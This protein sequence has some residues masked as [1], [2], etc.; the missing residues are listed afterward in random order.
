MA[1]L[2][3]EH[4]YGVQIRES[5][6]DGSDF[7]NPDADYRIAFLGEDGKWH[8]KDSAGTV[9]DPFSGS[10][11]VATDAIWDAAGD[12]AQ[13]TGANT[14]A[15]LTLGAAGTVV[16]STGST[17]AY[18][19]PPGYEF[20]YAQVTSNTNVTGTTSGA[21]NTIITGNAVTYDG[22]TIVLAEFSSA[23][24]RPDS[25]AGGRDL[26][27][28]LFEGSTAIASVVYVTT[29]AAATAFFAVRGAYRFTPSA[30]A[31]TYLIKAFVSAGTGVIGA[32]AAGTAGAP[33]FLRITKV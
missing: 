24:V 23:F 5:A 6:N 11:A 14:A 18:A 7:T 33:A 4:I 30:G 28:A 19:F 25:T 2:E 29:E 15:K 27:V 31:H 13:G 21:A 8:V 12:L 17:N 16:R 26:T 32:G 22:S 20:D 3:S 9:T 1:G 10:G